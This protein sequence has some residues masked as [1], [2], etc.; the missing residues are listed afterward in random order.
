VTLSR[1]LSFLFEVA[2]GLA[3]VIGGA[4]LIAAA[5]LL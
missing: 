1:T 2:T 5:S 4:R 3:L